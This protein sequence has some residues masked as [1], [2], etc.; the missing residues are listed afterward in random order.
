MIDHVTEM[1]FNFRQMIG[2]TRDGATFTPEGIETSRIRQWGSEDSA[3][4]DYV[5]NYASWFETPKPA[6][7]PRNLLGQVNNLMAPDPLHPTK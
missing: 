6:P 5:T 2:G 3:F 7:G 4:S 1:P